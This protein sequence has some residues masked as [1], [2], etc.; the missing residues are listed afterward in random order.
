MIGLC[1]AA[2]FA[3]LAVV[4][5]RHPVTAEHHMGFGRTWL[6][7]AGRPVVAEHREQPRRAHTAPTRGALFSHLS[8]RVVP[9]H[10]PA[11]WTSAGTA[12]PAA[13]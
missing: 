1:R 7:L 3:R 11:V 12:R 6:C 2:R 4:A 5:T 13:S 8:S 10:P 9:L